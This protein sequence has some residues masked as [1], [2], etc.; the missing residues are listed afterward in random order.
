MLCPAQPG[1]HRLSPEAS[2]S[3]GLWRPGRPASGAARGSR[4]ATED[5][6]ARIQTPLRGY[7]AGSTVHS[8]RDSA[9]LVFIAARMTLGSLR[10]CICVQTVLAPGTRV[11]G[12]PGTRDLWPHQLEKRWLRRVPWLP[13]RSE[14]PRDSPGPPRWRATVRGARSL[15]VGV[16]GRGR[17]TPASSEFLHC[18]GGLCRERLGVPRAKLPSGSRESGSC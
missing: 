6:P 1:E 12:N 3:P 8:G 18:K 10:G 7:D 5:D 14:R 13:R 4:R 15:G 16:L 9:N 17:G 11:G 2:S